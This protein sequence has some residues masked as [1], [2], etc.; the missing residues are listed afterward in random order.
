MRASVCR[1]TGSSRDGLDLDSRVVDVCS[2]SAGRCGGV[3]D[4]DFYFLR[5]RAGDAVV[6]SERVLGAAVEALPDGAD[7][8]ARECVSGVHSGVV[9]WRHGELT[10]AAAEGSC[11][12][13]CA[14]FPEHYDAVGAGTVQSRRYL[15]LCVFGLD[16]GPDRGSAGRARGA[17]VRD[18]CLYNL[19]TAD[20]TR[21]ARARA[22]CAV[23]G[24]VHGDSEFGARPYRVL[25]VATEYMLSLC[26]DVN[27]VAV[28]G[29]FALFVTRRLEKTWTLAGLA[30]QILLLVLVNVI[31]TEVRSAIA[32]LPTASQGLVLTVLIVL[33]EA[34]KFATGPRKN[35]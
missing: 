22:E 23:E 3:D 4:L 34:G 27:V 31:V 13:L 26:V 18:G 5:L 11:G 7:W 28:S 17:G 12:G 21:R 1:Y 35:G 9:G 19:A 32:P 20:E 24:A 6:H 8:V 25:V 2:S 15:T 33:F 10:R 29:A 16:A 30:A 14:G